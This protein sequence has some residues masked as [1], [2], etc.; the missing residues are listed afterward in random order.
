MSAAL[1]VSIA[2]LAQAVEHSDGLKLAVTGLGIAHI[3]EIALKT[4]VGVSCL[5]DRT[6]AIDLENGYHLRCSLAKRP[7]P[8]LA[9]TPIEPTRG[10][11]RPSRAERA[12][13]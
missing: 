11:A 10:L 13:R 6:V 2:Q 9:I 7:E 4:K 1:N 5:G 12:L 3:L 8:D